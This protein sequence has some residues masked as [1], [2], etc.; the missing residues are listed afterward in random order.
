MDNRHP[1][2]YYSSHQILSQVSPLDIQRIQKNKQQKIYCLIG[3]LLLVFHVKLFYS[4]VHL[5]M[6]ELHSVS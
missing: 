2:A 5:F 4:K 3:Q 6:V 1:A